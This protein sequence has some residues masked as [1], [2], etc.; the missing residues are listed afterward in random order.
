MGNAILVKPARYVN[1][2]GGNR[3]KTEHIPFLVVTRGKCKQ[4]FI[5]KGYCTIY[6]QNQKD[7]YIEVNNV[8]DDVC[9]ENL[10]SDLECQKHGITTKNER[11]KRH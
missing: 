1:A 7:D 8:G 3:M 10:S 2:R 9:I 11:F 6:L 5:P 4:V